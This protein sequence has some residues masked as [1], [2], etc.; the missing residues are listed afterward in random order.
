MMKKFI[1]MLLAVILVVAIAAFVPGCGPGSDDNDNP[2]GNDDPSPGGDIYYTVSLTENED[3]FIVRSDNPV[4]V[5]SGGAAEFKLEMKGDY[6]VSGVSHQGEDVSAEVVGGNDGLLTVRISD[7]RYSVSLTVE[8]VVAQTRIAYH[9]NGGKFIDG[10]DPAKPYSVGYSLKN[11]LRPNTELGT[12]R[13]YREGYILTGWN[14][15]PD[16]SGTRAGLGSRVTAERGG[17]LNLYAQ[18]IAEN[19]VSDFKYRI[20]NSSATILEY[21][22]SD[23][24]VAV[25]SQIE[26]YPVKYI[27]Y[28]AFTGDGVR[29]VVLPSSVVK[30]SDGAF[31]DCSIEELYFYD[32]I[33][34]VS[35]DCFVDCPEFST[36]HINAITA[37]RYGTS[38][39]YS[40]INLADKYD[41]LILNADKK[42]LVVFGGS[43]AYISAD[44]NLIEEALAEEGE[45]YVCINMA[46][47]GWFSG[48]AQFDMITAFL[49][50]GD[51][52]VHAPESASQFSLMYEMS[53]TPEYDGFDYNRL[54]LFECLEANYDLIGLI[55]FRHVEDLLDGFA[56]FNA[57]RADLEETTYNDRPSRI[58]LYGTV[59]ANDLGWIDS[60]GNFA[61]PQ[62][63]RG[64]SIDAGEADIVPEYVLDEGASG[65][66]NAYY[67]AMSANG[68]EVCFITAP[69]NTDTLNNRLTLTPEEFEQLYPG[70]DF[71][72]SGRPYD[73]PIDFE[74]LPDW[75]EAFDDAVNGTL[76]CNVLAPLADTL[77]V[78]EDF[79]DSDY[80]LSDDNVP[81]YSGMI[82]DGVIRVLRGDR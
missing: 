82:A 35:D 34:T 45:E 20:Y 42:K 74:T 39:L 66:L 36:V 4:S 5:K 33:T 51:I 23:A 56:E 53:M 24:E 67:D 22:G 75:V 17:T 79:F 2:G 58:N 26:G 72:Y 59:Y 63:P 30:I 81:Q 64:E 60:R 40:E 12:D 69:I 28:D 16:G 68:I 10:S 21:T 52:F 1:A 11:K 9:A 65:R 32:N 19:P 78:T 49:K 55:D 6:Y 62:Y 43:G 27:N 71:L 76:H 25:P 73:I 14:T 57:A 47:N 44:T 46:V 48:A 77:Y 70:A 18:W 8:C 15:E 54:R 38:N 61:L 7:I 29:S 41:I 31:T 80:H 37:P 50:E 3:E 13:L